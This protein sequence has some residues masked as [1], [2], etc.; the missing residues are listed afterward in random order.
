[1]DEKIKEVLDLAKITNA[2]D[3]AMILLDHYR[4]KRDEAK[5]I[6]EAYTEWYSNRAKDLLAF[7]SLPHFVRMKNDKERVG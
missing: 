2:E 5:E 6:G 3:L 7:I 4:N 1:M